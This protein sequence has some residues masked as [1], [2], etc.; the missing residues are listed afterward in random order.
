MTG[1]MAGYCAGFN[2]AGVAGLGRGYGNA[3]NRGLFLRRRR[4]FG[5]DVGGIGR[6]FPG[7]EPQ[8]VGFAEP[9]D[10]GEKRYLEDQVVFLERQLKDIKRRLDQLVEPDAAGQ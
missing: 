10:M 8:P 1:R 7:W 4:R 2:Q 6:G 5:S 9:S 3:F